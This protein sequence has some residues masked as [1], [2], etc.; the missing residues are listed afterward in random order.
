MM[1]QGI[2]IISSSKICSSA[3]GTE[4]LYASWSKI[5]S[6]GRLAQC[7]TFTWWFKNRSTIRLTQGRYH[8][9]QMIMQDHL[10]GLPKVLLSPN[11]P[12]SPIRLAQGITLT[13][14][15]RITCKAGP[16]YHFRQM[17]RDKIASD[18]VPSLMSKSTPKSYHLKALAAC[19]RSRRWFKGLKYL[20]QFWPC[21]SREK[22]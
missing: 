14:W 8:S 7:I 15:S 18:A 20:K 5:R 12:G 21:G 4:P 2:I 10:L 3:Q 17:I 11:D 6:P 22:E 9:Y 1:A 13:K 16:R 19:D